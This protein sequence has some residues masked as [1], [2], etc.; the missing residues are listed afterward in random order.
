M[1][2]FYNILSYN[3][4]RIKFFNY[5]KYCEYIVQRKCVFGFW[6]DC[7]TFYNDEKEAEEFIE[8]RLR[9]P[10]FKYYE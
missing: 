5:K 6:Y 7:K 1:I 2:F 10:K 8:D 4:Y 3:K 9:K